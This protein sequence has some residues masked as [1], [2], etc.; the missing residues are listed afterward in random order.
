MESLS[1]VTGF[2]LLAGNYALERGILEGRGKP[3]L[4]HVVIIVAEGELCHGRIIYLHL[5]QLDTL[6]LARLVSQLL[7]H[8]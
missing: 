3:T 8:L 2:S 7:L 5:A 6:V 1:D 4:D